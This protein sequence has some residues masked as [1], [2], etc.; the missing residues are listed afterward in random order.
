[1]ITY[2]NCL[3]IP[4]GVNNLMDGFCNAR[5]GLRMIHTWL[6]LG[7][8]TSPNNSKY[9]QKENYF[10]VYIYIKFGE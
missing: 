6:V 7:K 9:E 5:K 3:P 10:H 2:L 4:S 8:L 1:M